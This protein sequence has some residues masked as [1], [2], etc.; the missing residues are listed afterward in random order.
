MNQIQVNDYINMIKYINLY[1]QNTDPDE[2]A[3]SVFNSNQL[4]DYIINY[5]EKL[6]NNFMN[7]QG[8]MQV[9]HIE[10]LIKASYAKYHKP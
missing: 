5:I 3:L 9:I 4:T 1:L 2:I 10:N 6:Q 8:S 7:T